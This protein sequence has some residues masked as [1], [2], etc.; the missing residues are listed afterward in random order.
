MAQGNLSRFD[1]LVVVMFENRSFD[2]LLGY[3][4]EQGAV[5]QFDGLAGGSESNPVPSY[6]H[7][8]HTTV[9]VRMSPGGDQDMSNPNP[10]PGEEYQHVNTQLYNLV[11]PAANEFEPAKGMQKP[12]NAPA[13]RRK[14]TMDGFVHDYCSNLVATSSTPEKKGDLPTFDQY[15]VIM[16]CFGPQSVPVISKLAKEFAVY[17]AWHS[18]VPSQTFCNRSFF[19]ASSSSGFVVNEPYAK[20]ATESRADHLQP[21]GRCRRL[22]EDLLRCQPVRLAHGADPLPRAG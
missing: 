11:D 8:G 5:P 3:L 17:D 21:A 22:L 1:H 16:D 15:R 10:D 14:P 6:I 2:N 4:Y 7:D 18:A 20:W 13:D 9:P 19:H 12:W